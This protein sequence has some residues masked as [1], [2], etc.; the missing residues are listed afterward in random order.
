MTST[1]TTAAATVPD[2]YP[3][4]NLVT[5]PQRR[6]TI[7]HRFVVTALLDR[8][9]PIYWVDARNNATTY[10]LYD[11]A[12]SPR[13]LEPLRIARAFTAYQ[14]HALVRS[15]V[16]H[17]DERTALV[18]LPAIVDLY[19]DD[20]MPAPEDSTYLAATVSTLEALATAYDLPILAIATPGDPLADLVADVATREIVVESTPIGDRFVTDGFETTVYWHE[21]G[22]Q[23]T[24]P[25]WVE[26]FGA[27]G[28]TGQAMAGEWG[29][30]E[31]EV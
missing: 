2:V 3:G 5:A 6:T 25:Y 14:H 4:I 19:R 9:G 31:V 13:I 18:V 15:L 11:I 26:L 10:T 27:V 12:P 17:V 28:A 7:P 8:R 16:D 23:T 30:V 24:I 22:W 21:G 29:L 20:D 1:P